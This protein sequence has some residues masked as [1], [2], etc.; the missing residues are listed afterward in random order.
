MKKRTVAYIRVSTASDAQLH[1]YDFQ[2]QYWKEKLTAEDGV[3]F[4]GI[5]ADKGISGS[6]IRKR[7]QFLVMMQDAREHKFDEIRTKSVSRFSRNTVQ[8]L[9]AVRGLRDLGIEVIFEK[10]NIHTFEPTSEVFLT[11][12]AT[13][14]END[15]QVDSE[16]MKWSIRHRIEN[17]WIS[18]GSGVYGYKMNP[19]NTLEIIPEEAETVRR[20]YEM[21]TTGTSAAAIARIL[22]AEGIQTTKGC[23]WKHTKVLEILSNEKYKG[24]TIM[25][26]YVYIDGKNLQ[27]DGSLGKKYYIENSHEGIVSKDV[28]DKAQEIREQRK[29]QK[30]VGTKHKVHTFTGLIECGQCHKAFSHKVN[31]AGTKY[32]CDIWA[33]A[34]MLA[35]GIKSCDNTRIKDS[36]L[37]EKFVS[38][39][40]EF[41]EQRTQGDTIIELQK[42]IE[43]KQSED[44]DLAALAMQNLISKKA[45]EQEHRNLRAQI[46]E[47]SEKIN[48][49]KGRS[50]RE[51]DMK[52]ITEFNPE[53][54]KKFITKVIVNKNTVTFVFYNG[55]MISREYTNGQPGNKPGWN[56]KEDK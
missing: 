3:E 55:A 11:I 48:A 6:S 38:A 15:L 33:C 29:N 25:G 51:S 7:P 26:K 36:V 43:K 52:I 9:E 19:D 27:N 39:Y 53:K 30:L 34:T 10:E 2:E 40:N 41:I 56:K 37:K 1:S 21:Y 5:Y 31:S 14:A 13:I 24:D 16:R 23:K 54:V 4:V 22:N 49:I 18:I 45:Y 28:W 35:H 20:M 46:A 32:S 47:L 42:D 44:R 17:G 50:V 12:A 8:L